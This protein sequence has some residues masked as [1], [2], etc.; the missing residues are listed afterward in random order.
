MILMIDDGVGGLLAFF[1]Y[2]SILLGIINAR[3]WISLETYM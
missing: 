3:L 2:I 1:L